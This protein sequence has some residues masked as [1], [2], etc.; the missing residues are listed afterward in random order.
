MGGAVR[1]GSHH[2]RQV[3]LIVFLTLV[4]ALCIVRCTA[5]TAAN[6][7][8]QDTGSPL[9]E[10]SVVRDWWRPRAD[11]NLRWYWQLQDAIDTSHSVDVYDID[12][13]TPQPVIDKL[14]ARGVK[15]ICYFS[16]GT[17]ESFRTDASDFPKR[18]V[19][20]PYTGYADER[21]LNI[22]D[23][24]ALAPVMRDRL[25]RCAEK[26]FD[27]VEGDN[28]DAFY[29]DAQDAED[30]RQSGTGFGITEQQSQDYVLWLA[31][32]SHLRGLAFGLKNAEALAESVVDQVDW[33]L[34][35]SCHVYNWCEQVQVV[36]RAN[37]PVFMTEYAEYLD[38]FSPA[39]ELAKR[40]GYQAI[41]RNTELTAEGRYIE[42]L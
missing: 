29:F 28:V 18:A 13:D 33:V 2:L 14:K 22:A 34:T 35:E 24:E 36:R 16:V 9:A 5:D 32:E 4:S 12:I 3:S 27:G 31:R 37:K 7:V 20:N 42:C 30:S 8:E 15:L 25:D 41:L 19:G 40:L 6:Q 11:E 21:W 10:S 1:V 38:D 39:C 17:V 23:I 26:G